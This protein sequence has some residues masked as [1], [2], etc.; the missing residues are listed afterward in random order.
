MATK[1]IGIASFKKDFEILDTLALLYYNKSF[2]GELK[3]NTEALPLSSI[4]QTA[5]KCILQK[6]EHLKRE[7]KSIGFVSCLWICKSMSSE[8]VREL[9]DQFT[10]RA[11]FSE[12]SLGLY[13]FPCIGFVNP[14]DDDG[15]DVFVKDIDRVLRIL[16]EGSVEVLR[17]SAKS[18][19][20][21]FTRGL[22]DILK[23]GRIR[24]LH[25]DA[26]SWNDVDDSARHLCTALKAY[27]ENIRI[28]TNGI[29]A[30][31]LEFIGLR[32]NDGRSGWGTEN[33]CSIAKALEGISTLRHLHLRLNAETTHAALQPCPKI[34]CCKQK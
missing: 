2:R 23:N 8:R 6:N 5:V 3:V 25:L 24:K 28:Q 14:G 19:P 7:T 12:L 4:V 9:L 26:F 21:E 20:V 17:C 10:F 15:A 18:V 1:C 30:P 34:C 32:E 31:G 27:K 33:L 22:I 11:L 29:G 16:R 13:E